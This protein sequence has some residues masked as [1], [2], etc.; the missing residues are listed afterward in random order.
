MSSEECNATREIKRKTTVMQD[1]YCLMG[2]TA[3]GKTDLAI[4]LAQ[5]VPIEIISVDS[6]MIY[7]EMDIGS[8]KP[9]KE[10]LKQYPHALIDIINPDE[11]Y[12][13]GLF[14]TQAQEVISA[15]LKRGNIPVLVG[16]TMMYFYALQQ[17]L[18][19]LPQADDVIRA[20]I[21]QEALQLGWDKMHAQLAAIDCQSAKKINPKDSQRIMRA[22]EVYYLTGKPLSLLQEENNQVS[23]FHWVNLI[24]YPASRSDLHAIIAQRFARMLKDGF[25]EEV[26]QL[27]SKWPHC[28]FAPA[29]KAVGYRQVLDYLDN[30]CSE[31]ELLEKGII[32]TR[33]LAKRQ[34]TWLKAWPNPI[35]VDPFRQDV[36]R[37][38]KQRIEKC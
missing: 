28:R 14:C 35:Y 20:K 15:I 7:R 19:L 11:T 4:N 2:P 32:A 25:I 30:H 37:I 27:L 36:Y 3:V 29:M 18:S 22:L 34:C 23:T 17:G 1:V 24:L 21:Q 33:Q 16:G 10:I 38:I 13:V 26:K 8:A 31:N 9:R 12:S 5:T 6:A